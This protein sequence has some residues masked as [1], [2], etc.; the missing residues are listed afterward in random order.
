MREVEEEEIM[1]FQPDQLAVL[2]EE[3]LEAEGQII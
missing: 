3:L 1:H 2:E